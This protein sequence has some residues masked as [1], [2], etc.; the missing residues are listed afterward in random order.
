MLQ[1]WGSIESP[2]ECIE[3]PLTFTRPM[4]RVVFFQQV[5]HRL[6]DSGTSFNK[7]S[8]EVGEPKEALEV[9]DTG[10][11]LRVLDSRDLFRIH[12]D[13]IRGDN[14]DKEGSLCCVK[15]AFFGFN[16][17]SSIQKLVKDLSNLLMVLFQV[18]GV[19]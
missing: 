17:Q 6:A 3:Y 12:L 8:V 18:V 5:E 14:K 15:F 9:R 10:R 7:V 4:K 1:D 16:I 11:R 19:Y 13:T 2:F